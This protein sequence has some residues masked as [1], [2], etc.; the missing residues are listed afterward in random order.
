MFKKNAIN[1]GYVEKAPIRNILAFILKYL[2]FMFSAHVSKSIY[3]YTLLLVF[4]A[5]HSQLCSFKIEISIQEQKF[6][7]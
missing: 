7:F 5:F 1:Q 6:N 4:N 2:G 3:A